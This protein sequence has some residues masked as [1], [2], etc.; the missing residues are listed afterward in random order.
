MIN[1][2]SV[3]DQPIPV[4]F[5]VLAVFDGRLPGRIQNHYMSDVVYVWNAGC[6][7][8]RWKH[9]FPPTHWAYISYPSEN[10]SIF[11]IL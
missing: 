8:I 3:E 11:I 4:G 2:I 7:L 6:N 9:T 1:W 5:A 10:A